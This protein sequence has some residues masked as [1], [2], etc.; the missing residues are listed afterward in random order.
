MKG[1]ILGA[2][3][4]L[5]DTNT[6]SLYTPSLNKKLSGKIHTLPTDSV[7]LL[8]YQDFKAN[9]MYTIIF[10]NYKQTN[11][12]GTYPIYTMVH[13]D[14]IYKNTTTPTNIV[15]MTETGYTDAQPRDKI[16][17]F[18]FSNRFND[19]IFFRMQPA[20]SLAGNI[21]Y[22]SIEIYDTYIL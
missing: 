6:P 20:S 7:E 4:K 22:D 3:F 10:R 17:H 13:G 14:G 5:Q 12:V 16:V 9:T 19:G 8:N 21:S 11:N 2:R 15:Y 18:Y 1:Y